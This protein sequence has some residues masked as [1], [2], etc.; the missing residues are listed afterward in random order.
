MC[1]VFGPMWTG[2]D[3]GLRGWVGVQLPG[4]FSS[5]YTGP[6]VCRGVVWARV[7][8]WVCMHAFAWCLAGPVLEVPECEY[9]YEEV[10]YRVRW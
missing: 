3:G 2:G 4:V 8:F 5:T 9:R 1:P 7:W 6:L 10:Y